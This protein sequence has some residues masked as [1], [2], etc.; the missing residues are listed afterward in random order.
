M[1]VSP[2]DGCLAQESERVIGSLPRPLSVQVDRETHACA[3]ETATS[4]H[5]SVAGAAAELGGR[6]AALA[7]ELEH[8]GLAVASAGT[9]PSALWS[10][11]VISAGDR[12][13]ALHGSMRA[14]ARR[15]PTFGPHVHVGLPHAGQAV[16]AM[17]RMRAHL[18]VLLALSANSPYLQGRDTGLASART[19]LWQAFPRVGIPREFSGYEEWART[20]NSVSAARL[21]PRRRA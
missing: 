13:K 7:E 9:H 6:R 2:G 3:V 16:M 5:H 11:S 14:L 4:V 8:L 17:N 10:G 18:P 15:E 1:L 19:P 20:V 21:Y 12:Y